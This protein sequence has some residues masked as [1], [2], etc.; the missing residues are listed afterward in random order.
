MPRTSPYRTRGGRVVKS[1]ANVSS[2]DG[3][4]TS[5]TKPRAS[6]RR[7]T[8]AGPLASP[9]TKRSPA[10]STPTYESPSTNKKQS[11]VR[12]SAGGSRSKGSV[13]KWA[14]LFYAPN[15]IGYVRVAVTLYA[16]YLGVQRKSDW[17]SVVSLYFLAFALDAV[18]GYVARMCGQESGFGGVLDMVTDRT[19]TAGLVMLN[20]VVEGDEL[21]KFGWICLCM[22]D[23]GSH[24][25]HCVAAAGAHH[26]SEEATAGKNAVLRWYYACKPLFFACCLGQEA[27][28]LINYIQR[29]GGK[30]GG[31]AMPT[32]VP[33]EVEELLPTTVEGWLA[34]ITLVFATIKQ[35]VNVA[36]L[37]SAAVALAEA[38]AQKKKLKAIKK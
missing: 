16:F 24:W 35:L 3:S 29:K 11:S 32:W 20:L 37:A 26:K 30:F 17:R 23:I 27:F 5:T 13:S 12:K 28:Y 10:S 4:I 7:A 8:I 33:R 2:G 1:T 6:S 36:Q 22:L 31:I 25:F 18:D 19:A 38:D 14:V 9:V 15:V 21:R 34:S